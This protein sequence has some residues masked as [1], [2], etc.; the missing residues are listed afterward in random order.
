[1]YNYGLINHVYLWFKKGR[2]SWWFTSAYYNGPWGKDHQWFMMMPKMSKNDG[3]W[4][5]TEHDDI[6]TSFAGGTV[7]SAI[8]VG[9]RRGSSDFMGQGRAM[10]WEAETEQFDDIVCVVLI[11]W[12][13]K[14]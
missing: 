2:I 11:W 1:M 9:C 12:F 7:H 13:L 10:N 6:L 8:V 5:T 14:P 3:L 4:Q